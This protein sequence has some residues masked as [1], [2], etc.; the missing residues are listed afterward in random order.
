MYQLRMMLLGGSPDPALVA[1]DSCSVDV[2]TK[3]KADLGR[4][5]VDQRKRLQDG[6]K[7]NESKSATIK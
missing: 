1:T 6:Y 3:S 5:V 2:A 7:S 4:M